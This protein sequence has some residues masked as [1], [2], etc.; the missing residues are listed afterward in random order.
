MPKKL[1]KT[2]LVAA[3]KH[4]QLDVVRKLLAAGASVDEAQEHSMTPLYEAAKAGH[5]D[6][7]QQTQTV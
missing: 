7:V 4:G 5:Q 2:S 6:I 3:A 1:A